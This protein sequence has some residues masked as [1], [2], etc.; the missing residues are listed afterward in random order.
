MT[1]SSKSSV[2]S[3]LRT[4]KQREIALPKKFSL[5]KKIKSE[6]LGFLKK[7]PD[8]ITPIVFFD[9]QYRSILEK[10]HYGNEGERQKQ[11]ATRPQMNEQTIAEFILEINRVLSPSGHL[12]LWI[13]K[14]ILCENGA[15]KW[16]E[17][18]E[19]SIVDMITWHKKR[20][21][22]GYRSRRCSEHL[23]IVQ[24]KPKRAKGVWSLHDIP[25]VW[26]EKV[27]RTHAHNKP[28]LLQKKLIEA[29]SNKGDMIVDPA[30]GSFSVL[31]A[32][33]L[34]GRDFLGCDVEKWD[35]AEKP[36]VDADVG[37]I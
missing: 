24:K 31:E 27:K 26:L 11:R 23:L 29:V 8:K 7:L 10:Q 1:T 4:V 34:S 33:K 6:G 22:M 16:L 21:G 15:H 25:D 19:L 14:F 28:I 17:K 20:M 5:N 13:D 37:K 9:P 35:G 2:F 36:Y 12:F 30:A 3:N 18:T 32:C